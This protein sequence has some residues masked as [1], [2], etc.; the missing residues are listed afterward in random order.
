MNK[1]VSLF[2]VVALVLSFTC[3]PADAEATKKKW[4][5]FVFLNGDNNL[6]SAGDKDVREMKSVGS[7][8]QVNIV[9]LHDRSGSNDTRF[10]YIEKDK[11]VVLESGEI[12]TGDVKEFVR[13]C[14]K[15]MDLYPA[16]H[17]FFTIWN[18]GAG[19]RNKAADHFFNRG[20]SYDDSSG[21]S[22]ITVPQL[23]KA[24]EE[25]TQYN[26]GKKIDVYGSDACLMAMP[27]VAYEVRN[28]CDYSIGSEETEPCDGWPYDKFL[29]PLVANPNMTPLEFCKVHVK[30]YNDSYN[31]GSQGSSPVTQSAVSSA[32]IGYYAETL[33]N[34]LAEALM[35]N[36]QENANILAAMNATQKYAYAEMKDTYH[37]CQNLIAKTTASEIKAA[38]KAI[39]D[40]RDNWNTIV[41]DGNTGSKVKDSHGLAIAFP[42]KSEY[43]SLKAKIKEL[44]MS[45]PAKCKWDEFLGSLYFPKTPVVSI[46]EV[47]FADQNNEAKI[48]PGDTVKF[49]VVLT[50]E[51]SDPANSVG[52]ELKTKDSNASIE[53]GSVSSF[54]IPGLGDVTK[55]DL[56]AKVK[57]S[58]EGNYNLVF[59][60]V[61]KFNGKEIVKEVSMLI[62]KP[63][64]VTNKVLYV[65]KKVEDPISAFYLNALSKSGIKFDVWDISVEQ[66]ITAST[67]KKYANGVVIFAAPDTNDMTNIATADLKSYLDAGGNLF[68]TGQ[69]IGYKIGKEAFY[70]DYFHAKYI[71]DNTGIHTLKGA[72]L[73]NGMVLNITGG[74]GAGNQKWPD[75]I[76]VLDNAVSLLKYDNNASKINECPDTEMLKVDQSKGINASGS[77]AL[78]FSGATYDVIY[79]AFG[80]EGISTAAMRADVMKKVVTALM[81]SL[82]TSLD[83]IVALNR[84]R[85]Q[86]IDSSDTLNDEYLKTLDNVNDYAKVVAESLI[87]D[88]KA[89]K[90]ESVYEFI[91]YVK[92]NKDSREDLRPVIDALKECI[93]NTRKPVKDPNLNDL[94]SL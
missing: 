72:D 33:I 24:L 47:T 50:N 38:A 9:V 25:L 27:E 28:G 71:Q 67:L 37:L 88:F 32:K 23:G 12:N 54:S 64:A 45:N 40:D 69:D 46:K 6:S 56:K 44:A 73:F 7:T 17:Y 34:N 36:P 4:T 1:Y 19:I 52:L 78:K 63:F 75:E 20:I 86:A 62:R 68:I 60:V 21:H 92:E 81:P 90:L 65:T 3:F 76:D 18:H 55:A 11:E 22:H 82:K 26:G 41:A 91:S 85:V 61:A 70:K 53:T 79:F 29:A 66:A 13:F 94:E 48:N 58:C 57:D 43:T 16:E 39:M 89:L 8:D 77:G 87:N 51:G 74:D 30:A 14:K 15:V 49:T 83:R 2:L 5:V 35:K 80:F 59:S 93:F 42:S 84:A 10:L 31:G